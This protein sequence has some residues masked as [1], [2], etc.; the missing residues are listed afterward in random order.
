MDRLHF[1]NHSP[2][3]AVFSKNSRDFVVEEVPLYEPSGE[4]EHLMLKI[5]KKD[6]TTW[7]LIKK[8]SEATGC[9]IRDIGYAGLKDKDGLTTQYITIHRKY[10]A[11]LE[12]IDDNR[13]KI[14]EKHSH[15]NKLK[16][17]HL[18]G[19]NFFIRLKKVNA[20]DALKIKE[21]LKKIQDQGLPNYFGYQRFGID[22]D[23]YKIGKDILEGKRKEKNR[24]KRDF[25]ISAY[26]SHLFNLWL[27]RR[28]EISKLFES[29]EE[30]ELK[31][32][33][34]YSKT[35][36]SS[37]KKQENFFKILPGDIACHYPF[38]KTFE[39][40]DLQKESKRFRDRDISVTGLL[41]GDKT[42]KASDIAGIIE[43]EFFSLCDDAVISKMRGSR[44]FA[45]IFPQ[46]LSQTHKKE[47]AWFELSFYLPKGSYATVLIEE[48]L[49]K[50]IND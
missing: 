16:I 37:I 12:K 40:T 50:S 9:K 41:V 32:L 10:E 46:I 38:G 28:L 35:L 22:G 44:R 34:E 30:K 17:G 15:K 4:G 36:L 29:F 25:F 18:K 39:C 26:Q 43:K 19:N 1:L 14:L 48:L 8:V 7:D 11:S 20:T 33:F 23:N 42:L 49:K 21:A 3:S 13:I 45:W 47:D 31:S 6:L 5:R 24:K 27:S 2:I